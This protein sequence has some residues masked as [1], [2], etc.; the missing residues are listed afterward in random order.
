[1]YQYLIRMHLLSNSGE[2]ETNEFLY[3]SKIISY[4]FIVHLSCHGH[5]SYKLN[6]FVRFGEGGSH[7]SCLLWEGGWESAGQ[8]GEPLHRTYLVG[9]LSQT[10]QQTLSAYISGPGLGLN[11][12]SGQNIMSHDESSENYVLLP[13]VYF[14]YEQVSVSSGVGRTGCWHEH[15]SLRNHGINLIL[16]PY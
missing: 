10:Q 4:L 15:K 12:G 2:N 13:S 14:D 16:K 5:S 9:R 11:P 8:V 1:M 6:Q 7:Y 3:C